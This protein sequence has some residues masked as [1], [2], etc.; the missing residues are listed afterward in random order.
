MTYQEPKLNNNKPQSTNPQIPFGWQEV[1]LGDVVEIIGGG[2][3]KTTLSEYWNGKIPWLSVVDFN[4]DQRWVKKTEKTIT[5]LGLK[6]SSTKLL[7]KGDL[8]ISARGTV[9]VFAQLNSDMVFNQSC[10]GLKAKAETTNNFV[11]YILKN[12]K[13]LFLQNVHGAV[14]DTITRD[15]FYKI[16]IPLPPLPEQQSIAAILSSLDD[17]IELLRDQN[18][19]LEEL[20][21][22]LFQ[23]ELA[24]NGDGW[25]ERR[26][27]ELYEIFDSK[28]KPVSS[29]IR[30]LRKGIYPYHG[31]TSVM[32]FID[33]YIFD[34]IYLLMGEDG[35]VM[36]KDGFPFLQYVEGK[37]W[38]NNHAHVLQGKGKFTTEFLYLLLSK[39]GVSNIVTGGVQPKINQSNLQSLIVRIP[40]EKSVDKIT[41]LVSNIFSKILANTQQIQTLSQTRDTLLPR[42]MSGEVRVG[43]ERN[44]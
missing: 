8:I 12:Y 27:G 15:T 43:V 36:N 4:N 16:E 13:S 7:N 42:L 31:A 32:G 40:S 9:G 20:G 23:K 2:T 29:D 34:G 39:T 26:L 41:N 5:D 10:Y 11:Y 22:K 33:D 3:P 18:K 44:I 1:K 21:Q 6:N 38:V 30:N 14:F 17:K 25:Q 24:E 19:T 35:S 28:R 37:I